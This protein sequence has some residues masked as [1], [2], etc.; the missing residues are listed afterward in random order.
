MLS[1][2]RDLKDHTGIPHLQRVLSRVLS[3]HI[4]HALPDLRACLARKKKAA[5]EELNKLQQTVEANNV[6]DR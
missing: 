5:E 6:L 2:H 1:P 3:A 4:A